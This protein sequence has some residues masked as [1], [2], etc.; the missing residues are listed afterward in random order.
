[1]VDFFHGKGSRKLYMFFQPLEDEVIQKE[2][3][4]EQNF[5][6]SFDK[7]IPLK[8]KAIYMLRVVEDGIPINM[9]EL[10]SDIMYG[11]INP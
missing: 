1:M 4:S 2:L 7:V 10:G 9:N 8:E 6:V 11:E 3:M 5:F